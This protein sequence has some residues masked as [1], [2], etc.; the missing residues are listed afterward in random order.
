MQSWHLQKV[1]II[2]CITLLA[3]GVSGISSPAFG[4]EFKLRELFQNKVKASD[5]FINSFTEKADTLVDVSAG[6]VTLITR[7][8]F[9]TL[10]R[11]TGLNEQNLLYRESKKI[12]WR[13]SGLG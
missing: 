13:Q 11:R 1:K 7:K 8:G 9:F 10:E 6:L 4:V 2:A 12:V 3:I 5:K